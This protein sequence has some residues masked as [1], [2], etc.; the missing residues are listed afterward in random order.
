M[1]GATNLISSALTTVASLFSTATTMITGSEI[2]MAFIGISLVGGGIGL[3]H[4]V[5]RH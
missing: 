1:E 3:F 2:A 5:I 4:R